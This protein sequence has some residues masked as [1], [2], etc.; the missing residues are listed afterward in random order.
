M[1]PTG[2]EYIPVPGEEYHPK[3]KHRADTVEGSVIASGTDSDLVRQGDGS[4]VI[5][6]KNGSRRSQ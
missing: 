3:G 6:G 4:V 1:K 5:T 2:Y